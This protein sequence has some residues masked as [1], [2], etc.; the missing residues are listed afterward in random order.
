ML[1]LTINSIDRLS[2]KETLVFGRERNNYY[3]FEVKAGGGGTFL[4]SDTQLNGTTH[5]DTQHKEIRY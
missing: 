5:L 1:N 3:F 4:Y 2:L